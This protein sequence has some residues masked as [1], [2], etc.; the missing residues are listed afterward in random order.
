MLNDA[1]SLLNELY[2]KGLYKRLHVYSADESDIDIFSKLNGLSKLHYSRIDVVAVQ[3]IK[4]TIL[5]GLKELAFEASLSSSSADM[6]KLAKSLVNLERLCIYKGGY[7][8]I[9]PFI[10][11]SKFL[12]KIRID[13]YDGDALDLKALNETRKKMIEKVRGCKLNKLMV[14]MGEQSYLKFKWANRETNLDF[15]E[16]RRRDSYDWGHHF[17]FI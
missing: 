8:E 15:I 6:E 13:E 7:N 11:Y 17:A 12:K 10:Q 1:V 14:F 2:C 16:F 5:G 4:P 3:G 9:L